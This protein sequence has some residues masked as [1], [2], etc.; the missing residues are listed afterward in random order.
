M[1]FTVIL[2]GLKKYATLQP[3][4]WLIELPEMLAFRRG[5]QTVGGKGADF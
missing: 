3:S 5:W 4:N 2:N 1:F